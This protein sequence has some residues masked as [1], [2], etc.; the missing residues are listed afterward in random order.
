[1]KADNEGMAA[2]GR[3]KHHEAGFEFVWAT[4][5]VKLLSKSKCSE[6]GF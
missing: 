1:M 4:D 2:C 3:Y 6:A 5:S